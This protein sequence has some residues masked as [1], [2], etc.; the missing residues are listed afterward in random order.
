MMVLE[1]EV[2]VLEYEGAL[3]EV[4]AKHML[5][6]NHIVGH[7]P[8]KMLKMKTLLEYLISIS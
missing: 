6:E 4:V 7:H 2:V 3:E 5:D 8:I 1:Q